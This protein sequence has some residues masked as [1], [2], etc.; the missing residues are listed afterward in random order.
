VEMSHSYCGHIYILQRG[1][2]LTYYN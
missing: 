2:Y 1:T